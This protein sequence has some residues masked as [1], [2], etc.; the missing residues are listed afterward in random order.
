MSTQTIVKL[1]NPELV[2]QPKSVSVLKKKSYNKLE[3]KFNENLI[4]TNENKSI[5]LHIASA[6]KRK[7]IK[8]KLTTTTKETVRLNACFIYI[9][10]CTTALN[11]TYSY[12]TFIVMYK[13]EHI[14]PSNQTQT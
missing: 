10:V 12:I 9:M 6:P 3:E 4:E 11:F 13:C 8:L 2:C 7:K 5:S 14:N 1:M